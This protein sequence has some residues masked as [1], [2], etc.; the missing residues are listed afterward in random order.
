MAIR[1]EQEVWHRRPAKCHDGL[2][3]IAGLLVDKF[4]TEQRRDDPDF[5]HVVVFGVL[6]AFVGSLS[7][8]IFYREAPDYLAYLGWQTHQGRRGGFGHHESA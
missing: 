7:D 3:F 8:Q 6:I 1:N 2:D 5:T 4:E